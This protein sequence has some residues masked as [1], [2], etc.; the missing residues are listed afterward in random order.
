MFEN[1]SYDKSTVKMKYKSLNVAIFNYYD[2]TPLKKKKKC[3]N[4]N[5]SNEY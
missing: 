5:H 4:F 2:W 1:K 3:F